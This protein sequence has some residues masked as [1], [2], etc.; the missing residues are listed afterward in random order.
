VHV[1]VAAPGKIDQQ[2][3]VGGKCRRE[4]HGVR[5]GM[6]PMDRKKTTEC[7]IDA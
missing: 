1:F 4:F 7:F 6:A 5:Q 2:N 3:L